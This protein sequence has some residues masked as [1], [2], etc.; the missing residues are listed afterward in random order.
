MLGRRTEIYS[1]GWEGPWY[2]STMTELQLWQSVTTHLRA[3]DGA[4]ATS[5]NAYERAS[6]N[7]SAV[8]DIEQSILEEKRAISAASEQLNVLIA[9]RQ[10]EA[11]D[12]RR[13]KRK[14]DDTAISPPPEDDARRAGDA[15][16]ARLSGPKRTAL[17]TDDGWREQP[18]QRGRKVAFRQPPRRM[19]L[20]GPPE[21]GEVWI[22]ATVIECI[23]NDRNRYVVQDAEDEQSGP[24]WNTTRKSIIP[25]PISTDTLPQEPFQPGQRVLAL[26]PDTSCFYGA[27]VK[28]GGPPTTGKNKP[29]KSDEDALNALYDIMFDDDGADIKRV[30]AYLVVERP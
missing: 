9:L 6:T 8:S 22:L 18:L 10:S 25:L 29:S 3:L 14:V 4:R 19:S 21:V 1:G 2:F 26:Y 24:I 27:T 7:D 11:L 12:N 15:R 20:G 13:R 28:G 30:P 16:K 17:Q 23:N 5:I